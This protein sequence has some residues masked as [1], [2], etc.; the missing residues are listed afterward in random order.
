MSEIEEVSDKDLWQ[1]WTQAKEDEAEAVAIR[2][3]VEDELVKRARID[4]E[5]KGTHKIG[6][7]KVTIRIEPKVDG[8]KAMA[9]AEEHEAEALLGELFR[10]KPEI[11]KKEWDAAPDADREVFLDAITTKPARPSFELAPMKAGK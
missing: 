5:V 1:T 7:F 4:T 6:P 10:W 11:K 9:L 8:A 2:R 3:A